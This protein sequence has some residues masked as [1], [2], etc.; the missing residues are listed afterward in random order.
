M[1]N[2]KTIVALLLALLAVVVVTAVA[3]L[4]RQE[5]SSQVR[6]QTKN[7]K[8]KFEDERWPLVDYD[9]PESTAPE[10]RA[11]RHNK[12]S[13]YDKQDLVSNPALDEFPDNFEVNTINDWAVGFPALPV[14]RSNVIVLGEVTSAK[15]YLSNDKTG[16]Y[17]EFTMHVSKV[18]KDD[19]P[20]PAVVDTEIVAERIGGRIRTPSGY[21][22]QYGIH[23]QGMP[24]L[25]G[26][27]VLFLKRN[28]QGQAYS[29]LTGYELSDG[30]VMPLD[31]VDYSNQRSKLPQ[32]AAYEGMADTVFLTTIHDE[33]AKLAQPTP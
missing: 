7:P 16:I 10:E 33:I 25:N 1:R 14:E 8:P 11:K 32:F 19:S 13:R 6:N 24:K 21:I 27:Y 3:A 18:L 9:A 17:S 5:K 29:I 12:N 23:D 15:A 20:T 22:Q 30:H 31:G 2:H 4:H 26:R 28:A